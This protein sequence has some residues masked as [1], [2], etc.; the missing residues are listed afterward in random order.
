MKNSRENYLYIAYEL[1]SGFEKVIAY[2]ETMSEI[3]K[4]LGI[5][6]QGVRSRM[7]NYENGMTNGDYYIRKVDI[8]EDS[9]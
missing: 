9:E 8:D 4:Q 3:G 6:K 1:K 2:G 7:I 5:T